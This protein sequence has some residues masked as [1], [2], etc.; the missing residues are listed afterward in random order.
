MH[1]MAMHARG[2]RMHREAYGLRYAMA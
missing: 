1:V 2:R